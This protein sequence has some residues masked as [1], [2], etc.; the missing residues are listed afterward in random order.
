MSSE[1]IIGRIWAAYREEKARRASHTDRLYI[2]ACEL[3]TEEVRELSNDEI[4]E[5]MRCRLGDL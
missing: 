5:L 4:G 1:D 3:S 2:V